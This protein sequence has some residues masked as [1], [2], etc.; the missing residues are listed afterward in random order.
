MSD[1]YIL[2]AF[3]DDDAVVD[4]F[5]GSYS[6]GLIRY[7]LDK[8]AGVEKDHVLSKMVPTEIPECPGG[9]C[10]SRDGEKK[11]LSVVGAKSIEE[12]KQAHKC[13]SEVCLLEKLKPQLGAQL[14]DAEIHAMKQVS[15]P[16][17]NSLLSN[18]HIDSAMQWFGRRFPEFFPYNFNMRNYIDY[19]YVNRRVISQ[20]DTLATIRLTA[21]LSG[22]HDGRKYKCAGCVVNDDVYQGPGTH[23]MA[24]FM[25]ARKSPIQLE[26]FNSSGGAPHAAWT[27]WLEK[28]E[29]EIPGSKWIRVDEIRHQHSKTECGVYSLFYIFARLNGIPAE[30]FL[31]NP[32]PDQIMFEFRQHLFKGERGVV[33]GKFDWSAYAKEV[34]VAWE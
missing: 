16:T 24:L 2:G 28:N 34:R 31:K 1:L 8:S 32:V 13:D 21:L 25:D 6:G 18:V 12:A 30:Y 3:T 4:D 5:V 7:T 27:N 20:P 33:D 9:V 10:M 15:G 26:F 11:V 22:K 23:W 19:S 17:D 14:V 29:G